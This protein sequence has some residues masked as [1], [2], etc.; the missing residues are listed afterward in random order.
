[1]GNAKLF[2]RWHD[3]LRVGKHVVV[4][5]VTDRGPAERHW[6]ATAYIARKLSGG[7][8]EWTRS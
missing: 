5:V 3:D 2:A 8:V 6:V 1:M 7:T 4:V